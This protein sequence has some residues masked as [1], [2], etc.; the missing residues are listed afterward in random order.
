MQEQRL[1]QPEV[2][3]LLLEL[4]M[5]P[6]YWSAVQLGLV[7]PA[8]HCHVV[9]GYMQL[10]MCSGSVTVRASKVVLM[11]AGVSADA[12]VQLFPCVGARSNMCLVTVDPLRRL[13]KVLY[14][15]HVPYW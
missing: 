11:C 15:A 8:K 14:H 7:L 3:A 12:G 5:E 2:V 1:Q 13:L 4:H 6:C 9:C 10:R